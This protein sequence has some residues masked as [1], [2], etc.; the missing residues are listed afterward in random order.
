MNN[1][2][3]K[4]LA[5]SKIYYEPEILTNPEKY[6]GP[7]Y[8]TLLNVWIYS[9]SLTPSQRNNY[10][11]LWEKLT[12]ENKIKQEKNI[13]TYSEMYRGFEMTNSLLEKD[14]IVA[15]LILEN[16]GKLYSVPLLTLS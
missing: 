2:S 8:K 1:I 7:N 15:H 4:H 5:I 9:E 13:Y 10:Q 12:P 11:K 3:G 6:F 16:G 14:I